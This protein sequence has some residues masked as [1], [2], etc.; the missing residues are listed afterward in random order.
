VWTYA[1][2][3]LLR[4]TDWVK[5]FASPMLRGFGLSAVTVLDL[6]PPV[7][8][9][10][11]HVP[12]ALNLPAAAWQAALHDSAAL[13]LQLA[14]A[15]LDPQHEAVLVH[16]G[17]ID[18]TS[19][20]ALLLLHRAGQRQVSI[21]RDSIDRWTERGLQVATGAAPAPRGAARE[22]QAAPRLGVLAVQPPHLQTAAAGSPQPRVF[23]ASGPRLPAQLPPASAGRVLHL[24]YAQF[25]QPG[26]VPR[27][28]ADIWKLLDKSGVP[29]YAPI[30]L[31]GETA[32]EAAVNYVVLR[33]M[34][35]A[36]VSV[37]AP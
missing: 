34:G 8:F 36:D 28:A 2:P 3:Q 7:A 24:P 35:F 26:G 13:R 33:L 30:V 20:L 10:Q 6:R 14:Q 31:L 15:G 4:D 32:G 1:A 21:Y 11:G 16:E 9:A 5:A 27:P 37:W 25:L 23:I 18:E 19:A 29:R 22:W 12:Q 17:G